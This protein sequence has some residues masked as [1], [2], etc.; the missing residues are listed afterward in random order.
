MELA[1][2][3]GKAGKLL[4][5]RGVNADG[6]E[7]E[8]RLG[9]Y[10]EMDVLSLFPTKPVRLAEEGSLFITTTPTPGTGVALGIAAA[11]QIVATAPSLLIYNNDAVGGKNIFLDKIRLSCTGAGTAGAHLHATAYMDSIVRFTSGGT[12]ATPV[13]ANMGVANTSI[14]K[15]YDASSAI[16]SPAASANVRIV[17][18]VIIRAAIPVVNDTITLDF[19]GE[20]SSVSGITNGTAPLNLVHGFPPVVIGPQQSFLLFLWD[21]SQSAAPTW[22]YTITHIER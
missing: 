20:S 9:K 18:N 4:S 15:I 17:H 1:S 2:M 21:A 5:S 12:A 13:N 19:G 22:E 6:S 14:A 16:L 3:I 11:T 10:G 8:L 7:V